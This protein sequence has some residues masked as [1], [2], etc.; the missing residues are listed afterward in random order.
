MSENT[1]AETRAQRK[2]REGLVTSDQEERAAIYQEFE[3][4]V[5]DEQPYLFAWSDL[6]REAIN[7]NL[8]STEGELELSSPQWDWQV[9]T[10]RI[11][12]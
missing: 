11:V 9:E 6:A 1:T 8:E 2:T 5:Y 7:V 3:Q 10:L 4:I 12:E